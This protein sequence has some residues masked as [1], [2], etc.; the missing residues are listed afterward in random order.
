MKVF[1]VQLNIIIIALLTVKNFN[2]I[3]FYMK[4]RNLGISFFIGGSILYCN[5]KTK[6]YIWGNG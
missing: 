4:L 6:G 3:L 2:N 5:D 1:Y